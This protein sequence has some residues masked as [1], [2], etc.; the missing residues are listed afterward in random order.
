[1]AAADASL[2][3]AGLRDRAADP[4]ASAPD[5][6]PPIAPDAARI[7][8]DKVAFGA[9]KTPTD[10]AAEMATALINRVRP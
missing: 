1:M 7:A 5:T 3:A 2:I 4:T 8:A 6:A 9:A 10:H